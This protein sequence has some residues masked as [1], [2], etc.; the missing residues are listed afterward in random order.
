MSLMG[1]NDRNPALV[2]SDSGWLEAVWR[3]GWFS[4]FWVCSCFGFPGLFAFCENPGDS[5]AA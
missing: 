2:T 1:V 4:G 3:F 5:N